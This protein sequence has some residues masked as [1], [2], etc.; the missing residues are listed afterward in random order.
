MRG[1]TKGLVLGVAMLAA[2]IGA[3]PAAAEAPKEWGKFYVG[4]SVG[5]AFPQTDRT[6][7]TASGGIGTGSMTVH[8][9]TGYYVAGAVGYEFV[10]WVRL[11]AEVSYRGSDL[12]TTTLRGST[13]FAGDNVTALAG[14]ANVY[15]QPRRWAPFVPFFGFGVGVARVTF[16]GTFLAPNISAGGF[17]DDDT[18]FAWQLSGGIGYEIDEHWVLG[19]E[20]RYFGLPEDRTFRDVLVDSGTGPFNV[21]I[22]YEYQAH[23]VGAGLRYR[24]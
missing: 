1:R 13:V 10:D 21:Q 2:T 8:P 15:L 9:E 22:E 19:V 5:A 3:P 7:V 23:N 11:E 17:R 16:D 12:D 24:F 4:T 18:G 20:Y 14:M 6:I